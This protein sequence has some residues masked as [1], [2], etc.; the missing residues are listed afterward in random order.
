MMRAL[1]DTGC[2][3]F[4]LVEESIGLICIVEI[5]PYSQYV[6]NRLVTIKVANKVAIKVANKVAKKKR[7]EYN[8]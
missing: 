6:M 5:E 3:F 7:I 8:S 4:G 1:C 2:F